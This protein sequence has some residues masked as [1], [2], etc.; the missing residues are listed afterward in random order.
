M[1]LMLP[2]FE[3]SM[4]SILRSVL[5][6][7]SFVCDTLRRVDWLT[8]MNDR[9]GV[10]VFQSAAHLSR[11][12]AR[13]PFPQATVTY[14]VVEHLSAIDI[15]EHHVMMIWVDVHALHPANVWVM[16]QQDDGSLS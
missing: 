9:I 14:D 7:I 10:T 6:F 13:T 8:P 15:L 4:F 16:Q 12:L 2:V 5:R 3:I 1:I 11:K